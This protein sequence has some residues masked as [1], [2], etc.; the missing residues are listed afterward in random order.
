MDLGL[1]GKVAVVLASSKGLGF[2]AAQ[3]LAEA[4]ARVAVCARN[5]R[6]LRAAA[7][8]L[9]SGTGADVAAIR[10]DVAAAGQAQRAIRAALAR[11]RAKHLD[12]LVN[13]GPGPKPG[14]TIALRDGDWTKTFEFLVLNNVRACMA[15]F[16]YMQDHGGAIVNIVSTSVKEPIENLVLSNSLR[17]AVVGFAKTLSREWAPYR[18]RVN[19]VLPGSIDTDRITEV[20]EAQARR[21]GVDAALVRRRREQSIPLGRFG[22]PA[23]L[24]AAVAFLASARASYITGQSLS[25]DGGAGRGSLG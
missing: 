1:E 11:F 13:N 25:V 8:R 12:V 22:T 21:E 9:R 6:D 16:P 17:M 23:E 18:I 14:S 19:N 4:G 15:A 3:A 2:G 10:T 5:E 24:G 20:I 7:R